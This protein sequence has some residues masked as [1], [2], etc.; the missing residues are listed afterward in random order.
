MQNIDTICHCIKYR[1]FTW[2]PGIEI[3]W[4]GSFR[5]VSGDSPENWPDSRGNCAFPQTFHTRKLGEITVFYVAC[6]AVQSVR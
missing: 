1:N 6:H 5:I 3:L 2:F 4:N